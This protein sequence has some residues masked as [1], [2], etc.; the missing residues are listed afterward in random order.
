[1]PIPRGHAPI[2]A[3]KPRTPLN[4]S[5]RINAI[6]VLLAFNLLRQPLNNHVCEPQVKKV[7]G[8]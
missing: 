7:K 8:R 5:P 4:S 6:R 3:I 1:M 2:P